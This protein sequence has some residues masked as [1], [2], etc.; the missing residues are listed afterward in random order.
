MKYL[1]QT[2]KGFTFLLFV[3]AF[4]HDLELTDKVG[5]AYTSFLVTSPI[6]KAESGNTDRDSF[7][8]LD[9]ERDLYFTTQNKFDFVKDAASFGNIINIKTCL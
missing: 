8:S 2:T 4:N 6:N 7:T 3:T 5:A 1:Y 9:F